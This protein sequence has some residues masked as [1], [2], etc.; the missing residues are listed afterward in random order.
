MGNKGNRMGNQVGAGSCVHTDIE[1]H[2]HGKQNPE[3]LSVPEDIRVVLVCTDKCATP[4][5]EDAVP[6]AAW[7]SSSPRDWQTSLKDFITLL[8]RGVTLPDANGW[9]VFEPGSSLPDV[10]LQGDTK[11]TRKSD[12][13]LGLRRRPLCVRLLPIAGGAPAAAVDLDERGVRLLQYVHPERGVYGEDLKARLYSGESDGENCLPDNTEYRVHPLEDSFVPAPR[14]LGTQNF[15]LLSDL[16]RLF[17]ERHP[18][19]TI[20]VYLFVCMGTTL[21]RDAQ[22]LVS[23]RPA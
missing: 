6:Y 13:R 8:G 1:V 16:L 4:V 14:L 10:Q 9:C 11:G 2:L 22:R 12:A 15:I 19:G 5:D 7:I 18:T 23:W 21:F 20:N 3:Y 17:R